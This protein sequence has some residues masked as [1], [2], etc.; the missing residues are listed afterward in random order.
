ME[1][2]AGAVSRNKGNLKITGNVYYHH[3]I[4]IYRKQ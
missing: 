3:I 1:Q 2:T 4:F